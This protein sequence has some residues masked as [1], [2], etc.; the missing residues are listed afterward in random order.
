MGQDTEDKKN[1]CVCV[2]VCVC[3]SEPR[4]EVINR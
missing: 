4:Y 3:L 1:V 2:C